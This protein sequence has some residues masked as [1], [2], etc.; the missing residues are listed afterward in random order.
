MVQVLKSLSAF[1][2]KYASWIVIAA[3]VVALFFP[4]IFGWVQRNGHS[5][6]ILGIIMLTMGCTLSGQD[7]KILVSRPLDILIGSLAADSIVPDQ[8]LRS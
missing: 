8:A 3:A 2:S 5:S 6:V 4:D 1:L 7:F